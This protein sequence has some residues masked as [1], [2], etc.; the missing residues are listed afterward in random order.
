MRVEQLNLY[1]YTAIGRIGIAERNGKIIQSLFGSRA[2]P[3]K[4][5]EI[6]ETAVLKSAA[7]QLKAYLAGCCKIL[8]AA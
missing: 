4:E 1:Y 5:P 7:G 2:C 3:R 8:A 6:C